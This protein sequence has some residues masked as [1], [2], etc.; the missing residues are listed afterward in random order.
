LRRLRHLCGG[1]KSNFLVV[2]QVQAANTAAATEEGK[3]RARAL[4]IT[5]AVQAPSYQ[6]YSH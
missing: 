3:R 2:G 6:H 1:D 4:R 5:A